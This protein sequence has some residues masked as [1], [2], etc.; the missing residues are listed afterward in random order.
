MM[1]V[2]I[3]S[4]RIYEYFPD[5]LTYH[6]RYVDPNKEDVVNILGGRRAK[7][8]YK[9]YTPGFN[10]VDQSEAFGGWEELEDCH[11]TEKSREYLGKIIE[12]TQEHGSELCIIVVPYNLD[13]RDNI[14]YDEIASIADSEGIEFINF[15]ER[16]EDIGI[17][18]STDFN[19]H[20]HLNH[21]GS[22]KFTDY[23]GKYLQGQYETALIDRRDSKAHQSWTEFSHNICQEAEIY[24]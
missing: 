10:V 19:D 21:W 14:T 12:L 15:N 24:K 1:Q 17:D 2:S 8:T 20:T 5:F 23:L 9:G 18:R 4:D 22:V 7:E 3:E 16:L 11:L 6:S 13:E